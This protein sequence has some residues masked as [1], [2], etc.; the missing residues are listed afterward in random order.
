[1]TSSFQSVFNSVLLI[2]ILSGCS[3]TF[4]KEG[5]IDNDS[6]TDTGLE[7]TDT[8]TDIDTDTDTADTQDT[9]DTDIVDPIS[10]NREQPVTTCSGGGHVTTSS[11]ITGSYCF[12]P[13]SLGSQFET[14]S[15]SYTLQVGSTLIVS[16]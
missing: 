7:D 8:D 12:A 2:S 4:N 16:P 1:M 10:A 14:T 6:D 5:K 11:G 15:T 9:S 3:E 13:I